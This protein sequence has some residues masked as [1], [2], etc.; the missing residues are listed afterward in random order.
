MASITKDITINQSADHVWSAVSDFGAI[1]ERFARGFVTDTVLEP[2]ARLVT[3]ANGAVAREILV[4]VDDD[5]RR[6]AYSVVDSP[7]GMSHH[8]ASFEVVADPDAGNGCRLVWTTDVL[9]ESIAPIIA[10]MVE[11]GAA[12]IAQTLSGA[13]AQS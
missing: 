7:L 8:S 13:S 11:Q 1:H 10:E 5:R 4:D 2:G 9:P 12:A 6:L 3:F